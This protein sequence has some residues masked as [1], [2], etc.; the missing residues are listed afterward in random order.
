VRYLKLAADQNLA[1]AQCNYAFCLAR[2]KGVKVDWVESMKY[3]KLAADQK[4]A[5][6]QFS[7]AASLKDTTRGQIDLVQSARYFKLAADQGLAKAQFHYAVCLRTGEGVQTDW[8]QSADYLKLASDQNDV[9]A[10]YLYAACLRHGHGIDVDLAESTKYLK[11]ASD[12]HWF[13]GQLVYAFT[14]AEGGGLS[15]DFRESRRY[16]RLAAGLDDKVYVDEPHQGCSEEGDFGLPINPT[17]WMTLCQ[18]ALDNSVCEYTYMNV[19]NSIG[20][21]FE[22]GKGDA[23]NIDLKL[24]SG[25]YLA[26]AN[27]SDPEGQMNLGFCLEHGL[28]FERNGPQ[29]VECY[30]RSTNQHNA[31]GTGHYALS[32]HF[33][34][35]VAEDM[36]S[37]LDHYDFVAAAK[38]PFLTDNTTRCLRILNRS[39]PTRSDVPRKQERA[40]SIPQRTDVMESSSLIANYRV[41][42]IRWEQPVLLGR[43]GFGRVMLDGRQT[44]AETRIA[45]KQLPANT[46]WELFTREIENLIRVQHPCVVQMLG[47][48]RRDSNILEIQ[49][50]LAENGDLDHCLDW[51]RAGG[52][53]PGWDATR[54]AIILCD[55]VLGMRY[56]HSQNIIHRDLKPANILLNEDWHALICDFGFGRAISAHGPASL[57]AGTWRYAAPEQLEAGRMYTETVDLFSFGL[58]AYEVVTSIPVFGAT[59]SSKLPKI[60]EHAGRLLQD[61]IARC[62]GDPSS[63]PSF[64]QILGEFAECGFLILPEVDARKVSESVKHVIE[65]ESRLQSRR[66]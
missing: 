9:R 6:A 1:L 66:G 33:G 60:P 23:R 19:L 52:P 48:S 2:G 54:K 34:N 37:A 29:S 39:L 7:Y 18:R 32:L 43:G 49:M 47:W 62:W 28:G 51:C 20:R 17:I 53:P 8:V 26:A 10:Q 41:A 21:R 13:P 31:D 38:P 30:E 63:R 11:L 14:L 22:C 35:G 16:L 40:A 58:I 5:E 12:Q 44:N 59:R 24:A 15:I 57:D 64:G 65:L 55:I 61:L 27:N 25:W 46:N 45:V 56:V 36:E 50:K 42:P 3:Y 4:C